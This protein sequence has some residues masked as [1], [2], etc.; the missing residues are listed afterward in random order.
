MVLRQIADGL[1]NVAALWVTPYSGSMPTALAL[2]QG[3]LQAALFHIAKTSRACAH[4][5]LSLRFLLRADAIS[6]LSNNPLQYR[7]TVFE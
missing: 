6:D 5:A 1:P 4:P 2:F 7:G 3:L